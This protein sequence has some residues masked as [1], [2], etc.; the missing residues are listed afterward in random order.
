MVRTPVKEKDGMTSLSPPALF[1]A[2]CSARWG[3]QVMLWREAKALAAAAQEDSPEV[4]RG[5]KCLVGFRSCSQSIEGVQAWVKWE[6]E[7]EGVAVCACALS[8]CNS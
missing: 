5:A 7:K 1:P 3:G 2:Y 8:K 6:E 4:S